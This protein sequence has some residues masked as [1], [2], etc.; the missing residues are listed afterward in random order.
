MVYKSTTFKSVCRIPKYIYIFPVFDKLDDGR[1]DHS[2]RTAF[3]IWYSGSGEGIMIWMHDIVGPK[4][5]KVQV[6]RQHFDFQSRLE[7][8][9]HI[10]YRSYRQ[11]VFEEVK[12]REKG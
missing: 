3:K 11:C 1:F 7:C 5:P 8:L 12:G 4:S 9:L 2:R 10:K 6:I